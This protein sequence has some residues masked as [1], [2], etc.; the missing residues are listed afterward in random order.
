[1][2]PRYTFPQLTVRTGITVIAAFAC[3][4]IIGVFVLQYFFNVAPCKLCY[5]QRYPYYCA[6]AVCVG[7]Y[8]LPERARPYA[9]LVSGFI[10]LVSVGLGVYHM[11]VQWGFWLGP[12]DCSDTNSIVSDNADQLLAQLETLTLVS[13]SEVNFY[14]FGFSLAAWNT[15]AS[16]F[17]V[18]TC[19]LFWKKIP[20]TV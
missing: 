7:A 5:M 3:S 17:A 10:F 1:M 18:L 4:M 12:Q 15:I 16:I 13:C 2:M 8:L 9:F 20:Q 11:G 6:F 19:L 14:L